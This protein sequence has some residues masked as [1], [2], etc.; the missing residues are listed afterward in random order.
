MRVF[1]VLLLVSLGGCAARGHRAYQ[2]Q[3][4]TRALTDE[5]AGRRCLVLT[6]PGVPASMDEVARPGTR[7]AM[8]RWA[9]D[10]AATDTLDL[11]V[12]YG[13]DGRLEWVR[14]VRG[15]VPARR[16]A[17]LERVV[18]AGLVDDG[19]AAW[20][21][22]VRVVGQTVTVLPSV[23]CPPARRPITT[24]RRPPPVGTDAEE[25]EA[26]SALYDRIELD[27][28]LNEAGDVIGVQLRRTSRSRL[29]NREAIDRA[30]WLQYLPALHDDVG[31]PSVLR[32]HF[33]VRT[34]R[35]PGPAGARRVP[36]VVG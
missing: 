36:E 11:S 26:R 15:N 12:R 29:M 31:V 28:S 33:T 34:V 8:A 3:P 22:R 24:E 2:E 7:Y 21:F 10:S 35:R 9:N 16:A 17:D 1:I 23:V 27:V 4:A 30:I 18:R 6:R 19:P 13:G 20:G 25:A 32:V 14:A 5:L